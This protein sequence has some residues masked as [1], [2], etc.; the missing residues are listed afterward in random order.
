MCFV[1]VKKGCPRC[2]S[3]W[4]LG[5]RQKALTSS[6][7]RPHCQHHNGPIVSCRLRI[8]R[9]ASPEALVRICFFRF[10]CLGS[11]PST[12]PFPRNEAEKSGHQFT[13]LHYAETT[14]AN[15]TSSRDTDY[16][17]LQTL[18]SQASS[19]P[20]ASSSGSAQG[21]PPSQKRRQSQSTLHQTTLDMVPWQKLVHPSSC[22]H[23][24]NPPPAV[25]R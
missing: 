6:P 24:A 4:G 10:C 17:A 25:S 13:T 23:P 21:I 12:P 15:G 5:I 8:C 20:T 19:A 11:L 2:D 22:A 9:T 3:R 7:P 1:C 14:K 18:S 16:Q